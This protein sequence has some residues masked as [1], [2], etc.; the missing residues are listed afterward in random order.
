L[1]KIISETAGLGEDIV[2]ETRSKHTTRFV[3]QLADVK[4]IAQSI[5]DAIEFKYLSAPLTLEQQSVLFQ[6]DAVRPP[7][8]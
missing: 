7:K 1:S 6:M 2:E 4:G 3:T 8:K 5:Q